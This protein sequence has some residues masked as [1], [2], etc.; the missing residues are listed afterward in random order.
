MFALCWFFIV[1]ER[2]YWVGGTGHW[3]AR[4]GR[5]FGGTGHWVVESNHSPL[6][7]KIMTKLQKLFT[8]VKKR[9]NFCE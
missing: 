7:L 2:G 6:I 3:V 4:K 9:C 5:W 8:F 1:S